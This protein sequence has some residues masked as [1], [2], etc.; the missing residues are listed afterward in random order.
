[1]RILISKVHEGEAQTVV[2]PG[3]RVKLSPK[4]V[5]GMAGPGFDEALRDVIETVSRAEIALVDR[6]TV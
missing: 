1:M 5:F 4:I 3:R 6:D 2:V